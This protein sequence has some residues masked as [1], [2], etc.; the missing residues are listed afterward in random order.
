MN[1]Q[2]KNILILKPSALGDIV[3]TLPALSALHRSFPNAKISW[4][5]KPQFSALLHGHPCL[6]QAIMFDRKLLGK[7]WYS[8]KAFKALYGLIKQIRNSNFDAV[9]DFQGLL[10]TSLLSRLSGCQNRYGMAKASEFASIFYTH[11]I[12]QDEN[13]LHVVDYYLKMVQAAGANIS[14]VEFPLPAVSDET[15]KK[16][17]LLLKKEHINQYAVFVISSAQE[18]KC[19]PIDSFAALSEMICAQY[20]LS[21]VVVGSEKEAAKAA[22]LKS[23]SKVPIIDFCGRT[24]LKD[25]ILLLKNARLVV[26]NDT[27]PSY[28]AAALIRPLVIVYGHTNPA[29][30]YPYG[31]KNTIAAVDPFNRGTDSDNKDSRFS[32]EKVAVDDVYKLAVEQLKNLSV[33]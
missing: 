13:N 16:V 9:F 8:P 28:L 24:S 11:K 6:N 21:I 19:W 17:N 10:R 30:V 2:L 22:M 15:E 25:L 29:R 32:I 33:I 18:Y 31:R 26:G 7:A 3:Q 5:V 23:K 20:K 12:I 27:G 4:L 1:N 14:K